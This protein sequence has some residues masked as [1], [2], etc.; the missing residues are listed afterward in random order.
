LQTKLI[1]VRELL[2]NRYD[3]RPAWQKK[4]DDFV[5]KTQILFVKIK[6]ACKRKNRV[7]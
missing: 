6:I 2:D 5:T 7:V 1:P 3:K 4:I